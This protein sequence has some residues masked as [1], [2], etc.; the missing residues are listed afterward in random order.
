MLLLVFV[1]PLI[2]KQLEKKPPQNEKMFLLNEYIFIPCKEIGES[3]L[4]N[5]H[6]LESISP[7]SS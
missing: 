4:Q 7:I 3:N 1:V 2:L 6:L 5:D